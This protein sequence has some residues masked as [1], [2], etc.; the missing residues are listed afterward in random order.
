M[1]DISDSVSQYKDIATG[2]NIQTNVLLIQISLNFTKSLQMKEN[3]DRI[4]FYSSGIWAI[5]LNFKNIKFSKI[6]YNID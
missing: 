4:Q 1:Q 2:L 5:E 6:K 3:K